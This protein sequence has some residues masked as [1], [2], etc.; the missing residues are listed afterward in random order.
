[1]EPNPIF[2]NPKISGVIVNDINY[3][4]AD[5]GEYDQPYDG[6]LGEGDMDLDR[7]MELQ[8]DEQE[9]DGFVPGHPFGDRMEDIVFM[10]CEEYRDI[11]VN[12][13]HLHSEGRL[14]NV[15]I[16]LSGVMRGRRIRLAV[17]M[18]EN[19]GDGKRLGGLRVAEVT[20]PGAH[21]Y[22][23]ELAVG[24]FCFVLPEED[25]CVNGSEVTIQI[26]AHYAS[27]NRDVPP[28]R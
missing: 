13:I 4:P 27:F 6:E 23:R 10:P 9:A 28:L 3:V 1:M 8:P 18:Y 2:D 11:T 16:R 19:D 24:D 25:I 17:L 14:L 26:I 21:G 5:G 20:V 22:Q 7:D 12:K 15:R